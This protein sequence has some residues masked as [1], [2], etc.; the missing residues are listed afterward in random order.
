MKEQL[1]L[2][3]SFLFIFALSASATVYKWVD[4]RGVVNFTDDYNNVPPSYRGSV[5]E[6]N[7]PSPY[8][9]NLLQRQRLIH[10]QRERQHNPLRSHRL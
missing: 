6:T 7:A 3:L 8:L 5:V 1:V 2:I 9:L 4:E 10:S